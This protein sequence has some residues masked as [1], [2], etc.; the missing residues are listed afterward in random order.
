MN[1]TLNL[2]RVNSWQ[3]TTTASSSRRH[4]VFSTTSTSCWWASWSRSVYAR[5]ST[6]N[7]ARRNWWAAHRGPPSR[8]ASLVISSRKCACR[9]TVQSL[10]RTFWFSDHHRH[11]CV[12]WMFHDERCV[13]FQSTKRKSHVSLNIST[14]DSIPRSI[15]WL[16]FLSIQYSIIHEETKMNISISLSLSLS[17][18]QSFKHFWSSTNSTRQLSYNY[19]YI[20]LFGICF[21]FTYFSNIAWILI[22]WTTILNWLK[23]F[24]VRFAIPVNYDFVSIKSRFKSQSQMFPF[25]FK[26]LISASNSWPFPYIF[27]LVICPGLFLLVYKKL[28]WS[29]T[30]KL[31]KLSIIS[32]K[33]VVFM[34][35]F[36]IVIF[37]GFF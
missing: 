11:T 10:A 34:I 29:F 2:Q 1:C 23:K 14:I 17:L 9:T 35:I 36:L 25:I 37:E 19:F 7:A 27:T 21:F 4:R 33:L 5:T 3:W 24:Q 12:P 16:L 20:F 18:S 30:T 8:S 26:K 22:A 31:M 6:R 13:A 32:S 28:A 15:F